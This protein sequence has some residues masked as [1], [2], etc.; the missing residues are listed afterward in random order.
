MRG[1][2]YL[3]VPFG[4]GLAV[5]LAAPAGLAAAQGSQDVAAPAPAP[6]AATLLPA[7]APQPLAAAPF[8]AGA[9]RNHWSSAGRQTDKVPSLDEFLASLRGQQPQPAS[10]CRIATSCYCGGIVSCSGSTCFKSVGC[11]VDCDGVEY[12]CPG[13]EYPY[14]A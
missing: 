11:Y 3:A 10:G 8:N 2:R 14:C 5:L 12:D 9:K 13:C 1:L 4:L 7:P 6:A